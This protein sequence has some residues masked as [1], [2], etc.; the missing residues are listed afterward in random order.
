MRNFG[1]PSKEAIAKFT[2]YDLSSDDDTVKQ[3]MARD[4]HFRLMLKLVSFERTE[5]EKRA[6]ISHS[7]TQAR[8]TVQ[9]RNNGSSSLQQHY[10]PTCRLRSGRLGRI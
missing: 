4:S 3:G 7:N 2:Q 6:F 1:G 8:L 5:D 9:P 10:R